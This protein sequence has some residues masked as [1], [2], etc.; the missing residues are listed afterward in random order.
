MSDRPDVIELLRKELKFHEEQAK[1]IRIALTALNGNSLQE[2]ERP[3]KKTR[4]RWT[5][6]IKELFNQYDQL[7]TEE[8]REKLA[9]MGYPSLDEQYF[10]TIQNTLSRQVG[11]FLERVSTGVYRKKVGMR[12][13]ASLNPKDYSGPPGDDEIPF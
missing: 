1:R 6:A 7:N 9:E 2:T 10:N 8:V 12:K 4:V 5:A 13:A 3:E 11:N